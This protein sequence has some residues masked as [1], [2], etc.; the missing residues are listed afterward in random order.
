MNSPAIITFSTC[1]RSL[2]QSRLMSHLFTRAFT[3]GDKSIYL[4][5]NKARLY[6]R[7]RMNGNDLHTFVK[8]N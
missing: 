1:P 8:K 6:V 4:N 5:L 2:E 7:L 3:E